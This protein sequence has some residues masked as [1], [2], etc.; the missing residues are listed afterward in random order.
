VTVAGNISVN[1]ATMPALGG[2]PRSP[3]ETSRGPGRAGRLVVNAAHQPW[4][5][6]ATTLPA[7][8]TTSGGRA[9]PVRA[10]PSRGLGI[11]ALIVLGAVALRPL[12]ADGLDAPAVRSWATI[13]VAISVQAVPFL[14]LGVVVSGAIAAFVSPDALRRLLPRAPAL[15]VPVAAAA[16]VALPG[17]ECGSVPIAGRLIAHRVAPAAAVTFLLAAPAVNPVVL[18]ATAVAFPGRPEM[19]AARFLASM[20][21]AITVGWVWVA[22]GR[23]AWTAR[24]LQARPPE[25]A[26]WVTFVATAQ[27]DFLHAGGFLVIGAAAA[28]TLQTVVPRSV[29]DAMADAGVFSV[30]ALAGL[31]FV[32]AI[33][34]EADAFVAAGLTQFSLTARLAFLVVGPMVDVKLVALQVGTFGRPFAMRFGPL[35]FVAAVA[36]ASLVGWVLL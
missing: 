6:A 28:A 10:E 8:A 35:T 3:S 29:L 14:V 27:H 33:C 31:A 13:F 5:V 23:T 30:L 18:V 32:L 15:A 34:S 16:G 21:A 26:P 1:S 17:C 19:V 24:A 9:A 2:R 11:L 36:W 20:A 4:A 22:R 12:V 7:V 25:A